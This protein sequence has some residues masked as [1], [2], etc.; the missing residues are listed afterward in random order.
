MDRCVLAMQVSL[1]SFTKMPVVKV[2]VC[3]NTFCAVV[4]CLRISGCLV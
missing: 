4:E 1:E 2:R 3:T